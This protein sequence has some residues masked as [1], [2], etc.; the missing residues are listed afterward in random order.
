VRPITFTDSTSF[1][2]GYS[3]PATA[4]VKGT[5]TNLLCGNFDGAEAIAVM[6][7]TG[8]PE[9]FSIPA[10]YQD[11]TWLELTLVKRSPAYRYPVNLSVYKLDQSWAAD[12]TSLIQDANMTLITPQEFTIPDTVLTTGT[13]IRIPIPMAE[14]ENWS[15][16]SDTLGLTLVVKSNDA[17]YA[18][19]R[20]AETGRGPQLRFKY[21]LADATEDS[22][23]KARAT[24]DSYRIDAGLAPLLADRWVVNNIAPSRLYVN[25]LMDY[26]R[27][28]DNNGAVLNEIQRK[29]ATIN[30]AEL[31][32][33]ARTNPYYGGSLQYSLR[34]DRVDDSLFVGQ[35]VEIPDGST[36]SGII[37]QAYVRGDSVVVNVTPLIQA[38]SS[39]DKENYG[40][41]IK[42]LQELLN[43]GELELWHFTDAP[44]DKQP[45]LKITYTP[46]Y[47]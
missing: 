35:P 47:L 34:G 41:V 39:G 19:I 9:E 27:F 8:L 13:D 17:A 11:S 42:S 28:T 21:R 37:T 1:F 15:S 24:K 7:F 31:I 6:R 5:E 10:G 20:A 33:F 2:A 43:F 36:S 44:A 18:E 3:F 22:E 26:N 4:S 38:Y 23:Y 32:F 14:L 12:S 25:F 46:P 40:I 29:R 16:P 30:K 45:R